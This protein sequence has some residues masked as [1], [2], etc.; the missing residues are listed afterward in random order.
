MASTCISYFLCKLMSWSI[1]ECIY[2]QWLRF[3]KNRTELHRQDNIQL[4]ACLNGHFKDQN[5]LL[6]TFVKLELI[7][8][9]QRDIE[10]RDK[11]HMHHKIVCFLPSAWKWL[12]C[13][14]EARVLNA[15]LHCQSCK[16]MLAPETCFLERISNDKSHIHYL[17]D[18]YKDNN[19]KATLLL[20]QEVARPCH[21]QHK[22][23]NYIFQNHIIY[24]NKT[25]DYVIV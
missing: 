14:L 15:L 2:L 4:I 22:L 5:Q 7:F 20:M 21:V 18:M 12:L 9:C 19:F 3:L 11:L 24:M 16:M 23:P 1:E 25:K 13:H 17:C 6:D 8:S 10:D